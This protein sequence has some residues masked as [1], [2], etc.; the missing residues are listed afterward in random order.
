MVFRLLP[1]IVLLKLLF[2]STLFAD[3]LVTPAG[4]LENTGIS[5]TIVGDVATQPAG[6]VQNLRLTTNAGGS[7]TVS[8]SE[9]VNLTLFNSENNGSTVNFD[10]DVVTNVT[11]TADGGDWSYVGGDLI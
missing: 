2:V 5:Y 8:F 4:T 7:F 6:S 1:S 11:L 10:G 9:P 3:G